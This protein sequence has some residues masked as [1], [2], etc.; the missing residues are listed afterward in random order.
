LFD[1]AEAIDAGRDQQARD[2]LSG[3]LSD[4]SATGDA[5]ERVTRIFA[6]GL[7]ARL[8]GDLSGAGNL[9]LSGKD[10]RDMLAAFLVLV[11]STPFIRFG[12]AAANH[13]LA[14][15]LAAA[16]RVHVMDI[17]IGSGAQWML[18]LELL[19]A[20]HRK[21]PPVH[22]TGIDV[23]APGEYPEARLQQAGAALAQ[24]A[25]ELGIPFVYDSVAGLVERLDLA[26]LHPRHDE[27]LAVNAAFA[28][29]HLSSDQSAGD[30][31]RDAVLRRIRDLRPAALT[32]VEPEVEHNALPF[33]SRVTESLMH[34]L[35]VFDALDAQLPRDQPERSTL[36]E[37]FFGREILNILGEGH[38]RVERHERY[39]GWHDRLCRNGYEAVDLAGLG[40]ELEEELHLDPPFG[41]LA[42]G[43]AELLTWKTL[44]VVA[45]S[46]WTPAPVQ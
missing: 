26:A 2:V 28:L 36:E 15:A 46:A 18:F 20:Q 45:A 13:A 11:R 44:P 17:G 27:T 39:S 23:P 14:R 42:Y 32:L 24:R 6:H 25:A 43:G 12:Y 3:I 5:L 37:A 4:A 38:D 1:A 31:S 35:T 8:D 22:L 16:D 7:R 29:H 40:G 9:Y 30:H 21:S 34:Y 10:P 41:L 33:V 19:A